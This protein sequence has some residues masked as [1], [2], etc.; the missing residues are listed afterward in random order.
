VDTLATSSQLGWCRYGQSAARQEL[1]VKEKELTRA[2]HAM[3][4]LRRRM[5][6]VP[7]D[8]DYEFL[9]PEGTAQ[10]CAAVSLLNC[11]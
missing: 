9:G 1:L 10:S 5:P 2:G 8:K 4:A 11:R 7:V 6:W 3:A